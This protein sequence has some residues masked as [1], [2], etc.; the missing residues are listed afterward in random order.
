MF[1]V[2]CRASGGMV[3]QTTRAHRLALKAYRTGGQAMQQA[4][5]RQFF[6]QGCGEGKDIGN[7]ELLADIAAQAG[8]MGRAEVRSSPS[9]I[10]IWGWC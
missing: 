3:S 10:R 1:M 9:R 4:V 6:Y 7:Y 2:V 5:I 8:V